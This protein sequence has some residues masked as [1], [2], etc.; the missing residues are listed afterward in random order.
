[1][2]PQVT[3]EEINQLFRTD[4]KKKDFVLKDREIIV[5]LIKGTRFSNTTTNHSLG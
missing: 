4:T 1:M 2:L 3:A 5:E